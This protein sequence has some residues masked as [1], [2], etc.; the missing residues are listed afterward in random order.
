ME[1]R[2]NSNVAIWTL[3]L[4][5]GIMYLYSGYDLMWHPTRWHWALPYWAQQIIGQIVALD[6]YIQFQGAVEILFALILILWFV[7][8]RVV[9]V[10]ALFSA[11]EFG[12]ILLLALLPWNETV[13][14]TTF[15]DIGLFGASIALFIMI[16]QA[17]LLK[18][19][20]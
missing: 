19:S 15:R 5:L 8:V 10:V 9:A 1:T 18:N 20:L 14:F 6:S 17:R 4:S 11:L 3:R 13:F 16:R 2:Y 12:I 7:R